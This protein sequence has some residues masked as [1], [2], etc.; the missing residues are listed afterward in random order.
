MTSAG[1]KR[2]VRCGLVKSIDDF[3]RCPGKRD[4]LQSYCRECQKISSSG[5]VLREKKIRHL[6]RELRQEHDEE[7]ARQIEQLVLRGEHRTEMYQER[8]K[9]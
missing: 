7:Q 1:T 4:G 8:S 2:C 9:K 6:K 3:C 5:W